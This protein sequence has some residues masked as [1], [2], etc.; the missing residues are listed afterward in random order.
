MVANGGVGDVKKLGIEGEVLR[1]KG[2]SRPE[3][4]RSQGGTGT[5]SASVIRNAKDS[6]FFK[7]V[8]KEECLLSD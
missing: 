3:E 2:S 5:H 7:E 6:R 8:L 1:V 4:C